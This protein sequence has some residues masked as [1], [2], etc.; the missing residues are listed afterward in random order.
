MYRSRTR[1]SL[2]T[3]V[4]DTTGQPYN[5]DLQVNPVDIEKNGGI[6]KRVYGTFTSRLGLQVKNVVPGLTLDV[7]GWR[8]QGDYNAEKDSR[9]ITWYGRTP[10]LTR[11]QV[12]VPNSISV[13]K[14]KSFQNNLQSFLTYKLKLNKHEFTI[15]QGGSYE[16]F[17]K[18]EM[19]SIGQNMANNDFFSLSYADPLTVRSSQKIEKWVLASLFGRFNYNFAGKYLLE[20]SY[21]YDGSSRLAPKH[22]WQVF[23]SFSAAWRVS[24]EDFFKDNVPFVQNFKVR[25]SW[26]Q[27]GNGSPLGLYPYMPLLV[28]GLT[29]PN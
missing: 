8:N 1:Q 11:A 26:G 5:G 2:Y 19:N 23:P 21:R 14:N 20:A 13:T 22:R 9:S 17:R 28:S 10:T 27:L 15:M 4:E 29:N 7:I 12:N 25:G 6:D 3:P 24:E 18:D 16:E